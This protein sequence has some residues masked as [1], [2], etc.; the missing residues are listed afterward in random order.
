[1][2]DPDFAGNPAL[3]P[4]LADL[5]RRTWRYLG[6]D[7]LGDL[8]LGLAFACF[9]AG[10]VWDLGT[11]AAVAPALFVIN[12]KPLHQRFIG[13]RRGIARLRPERRSFLESAMARMV[14]LQV[15]LV[16]T[17]VVIWQVMGQE[18][19][20]ERLQNVMP[21]VVMLP[22]PLILALLGQWYDVPRFFAQAAILLLA[23]LGCHVAGLVEGW[24]LLLSGALLTGHGSR[25]LLRF[26]RTHP[27]PDRT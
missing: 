14:T 5:E 15:M 12:W 20:R 26:F 19:W 25:Q 24:P 18:A 10:M 23:I 13:P 3:D 8:M 21:V 2:S 9:G 22:F 4:E 17:G 11:F 1:M 7:G 16:L 6:D 27:R